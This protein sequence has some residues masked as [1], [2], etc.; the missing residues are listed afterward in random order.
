MKP[1]GV[2]GVSTLIGA[3]GVINPLGA[4]VKAP[5]DIAGVKTPMGIAGVKAL[6][7]I[8]G[9]IPPGCTNGV[10]RTGPPL[11]PMLLNIL[12]PTKG[13]IGVHDC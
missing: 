2:A 5:I 13:F 11:L 10:A 4:G 9:S 12:G 8:C 6:G 7:A 1:R 3:A